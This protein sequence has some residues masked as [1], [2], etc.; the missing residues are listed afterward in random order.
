MLYIKKSLIALSFGTLGLGIAEFI[1]IGI[2]PY[3]ATDFGITIPTAGHL[4]SAYASGVFIGAPFLI[5][6]RRYPLKNILLALIVIIMLGNLIASIAF[7]YET[8]MLARFISGLPHGSYFGVGS[9]IAE[10]LSD[11][12][13]STEAISIMISGMTVANL[14]GVPLGTF[15]GVTLSWRI[16]FLIVVGWGLVTFFY[17]WRWVPQIE[18]VPDTGLKGQFYFLKR[19]APWLLIIATILGNGAVFCWYSYIIPL[20]TNVSGFSPHSAT[21]LIVFAGVGMVI[22]NFFGGVLSDRLMPIRIAIF[23]Q[24]LL[25]IVLICI[26]FFSYIPWVS[27]LLMILGTA[28]LFALSSPQQL[29]LIKFSKGGEL[30][31]TSSAQMAFNLGNAIG[32]YCGGLP[33]QM[34]LGYQY[35][36]LVGVPFS[37]IGCFILYFFYQKFGMIKVN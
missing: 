34:G 16:G 28:C 19:L 3:I 17:V 33:I 20:L 11:K 5:F 24:G 26:F 6:V 1:I 13:K 10:K 18:N 27:I 36:A 14:F 35:S 15:L 2:L 7:N 37:V 8:M 23:I 22:G 29:L 25:S 4:I 31:G 21:L 12:G 30:L 32:A 9:I